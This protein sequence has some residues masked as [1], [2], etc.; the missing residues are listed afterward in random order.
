M[1]I[2]RIL[3]SRH[4]RALESGVGAATPSDHR[5]VFAVLARQEG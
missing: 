4:L 3:T 2:D 1:R 5:M